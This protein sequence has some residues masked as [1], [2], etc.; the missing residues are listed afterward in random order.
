MDWR[1]VLF[2]RPLKDREEAGRKVVVWQGLSVLSPDALSSVA[3]GTQE[4]LIVL[5]SASMG[6]LWFSLPISAI[7]VLLLTFLVIN[8]RQIITAYPNGGGAYV[9]GRDTL[10]P[11]SGVLAGS[12]LLID[13]TLTVS[14]SITAG[15][16]ALVSAFPALL[17]WTVP[18]S[19]LFTILMMVVNLR[20][21]RESAQLFSAPTYLFIVMVLIMAIY[22]LI[23]P[24]PMAR[25]YHAFVAPNA[26][27]LLVAPILLMRA[28]SS[29]S[30]ALTGVE[31]ISNGVPIFQEPAPKRARTTLALLGIFLGTMFMG[32]SLVAYRF[33]IH[34]DRQD[35]F[36]VTVLQQIA[37]HLFGHGIF[38]F[39][40][41]FVTMAILAVAANT[42]FAGFPQLASIMARDQWMPRM[43]LSR[44]DRLVYQNG[45]L[46]LGGFAIL[47]III[48]NGN[49][50]ALIPLYAIGVYMSFTIAM[51]SLVK[52][53]WQEKEAPGRIGTI[54]TAGIGALLTTGVV[55]ISVITKFT[56]GAWIVTI[57]IPLL[58]ISFRSV[59]RH[60][61]MVAQNLRLNDLTIK[62]QA[63][64]LVVVVPLASIN[65]MT[66]LTMST[67]L[68]MNPDEL[69]AL[70]IATSRER[71]QVVKERWSQWN[72]DPRIKFVSIESQ[73]R[74]VLRPMVRY[75]DHL[76]NL[77][78]P[79]RVIVVVPELVVGKPWQNFLHNHM[80][81]A[82]EA[83]LVF[84]RE[85]SVMVVPY[86]LPDH[87]QPHS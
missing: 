36:P 62:P 72:P 25:P 41:S 43:F 30:S 1:R 15:V 14:V 50:D 73:Y 8:Y 21:I 57:A 66:M 44:G 31:A 53:R 37:A 11:W 71:T 28:F 4:I 12:A 69:I 77:F 27:M 26:T 81:F 35:A 79:G 86:H 52:K 84:R 39:L 54:I 45:I 5:G 24:D 59:R 32:T 61:Q 49:T 19:V 20:G 63:R 3:Y 80:A 13:Y 22:G 48:F 23:K 18:L 38:F 51:T 6:A 7:I 74:S 85:V 65:R 60:Y 70:H 42:S 87:P 33:G 34:P 58:V 78:A 9:I 16:A 17:P 75:I 46:V 82:L 2:G 67:A 76:T 47:L 40:L 56:E 68:S 10:G 64:K 83:V 55:V 29:G